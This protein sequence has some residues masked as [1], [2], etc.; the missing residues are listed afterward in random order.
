MPDSVLCVRAGRVAAQVLL[1]LKMLVLGA[2][3]GMSDRVIGA[4]DRWRVK[5]RSFDRATVASRRGPPA[6]GEA[7][8]APH[9]GWT[10]AGCPIAAMRV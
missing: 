6:L 10:P 1:E 9:E 5:P 2:F 4:T 7:M 3:E 8:G